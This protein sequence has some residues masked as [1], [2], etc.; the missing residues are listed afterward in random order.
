MSYFHLKHN[1]S[2]VFDPTYPT[3]DVCGIDKYY[4]TTLYGDF[5]EAVP[6]NAPETLGR[7]VFLRSNV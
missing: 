7:Y 6:S 4:W 5:K 3:L 2:L 1:S